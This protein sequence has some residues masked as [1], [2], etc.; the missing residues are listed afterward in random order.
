MGRRCDLYRRFTQDVGIV[1]HRK[2]I[3]LIGSQKGKC[4]LAQG[5]HLGTPLDAVETE[6][7]LRSLA[8]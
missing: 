8:S 7:L 5:R 1:V 6:D 4:Q 3:T 2:T